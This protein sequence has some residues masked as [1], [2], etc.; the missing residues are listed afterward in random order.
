MTYI[1]VS[2]AQFSESGIISDNFQRSKIIFDE[3]L[4]I[5]HDNLKKYKSLKMSV[6]VRNVSKFGTIT[7]GT[8][9]YWSIMGLKKM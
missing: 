7:F 4:Q 1:N 5:L 3:R 9:A 2:S 6:K 8:K